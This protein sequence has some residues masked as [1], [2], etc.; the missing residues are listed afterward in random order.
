MYDFLRSHG[1]FLVTEPALRPESIYQSLDPEHDGAGGGSD[2]AAREFPI[3]GPIFT[4][5]K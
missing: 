1:F 2:S 4:S 5:R 3:S